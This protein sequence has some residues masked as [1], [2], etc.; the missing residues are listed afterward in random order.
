V[1]QKE[2]EIKSKSR[3]DIN[4]TLLGVIFTVFALIISLK[5]S[6]F[7]ESLFVPFE[8]TLAVPLLLSS[9][10]ARSKLAFTKRP[11]MWEKYGFYTFLLGYSFLL[12]VLGILLSNS[13]SL[14]I[15][16]A[17]FLFN[18]ITSIIY[19]YLEVTENRAKLSSRIKKDCLFTLLILV[20]GILP[21]L[22]IL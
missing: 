9:I 8:L 18:I 11:E 14:T 19:S 15:G 13:I 2:K 20:G 7:K 12:N 17:F 3:L 4:R 1:D 6:L 22:R 10:F 21:S 16:I 5:P